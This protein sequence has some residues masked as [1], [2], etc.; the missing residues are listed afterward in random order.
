MGSLRT[1]FQ[2]LLLISITFATKIDIRDRSLTCG[3]DKSHTLCLPDVGDACKIN[4]DYLVGIGLTVKEQEEM[5]DL[6]N[7]YRAEVA[8]GKVS[9]LPP[10]ANMHQLKWNEDLAQVAQKWADQCLFDHDSGS[11]RKIPAFDK[12]GQNIYLQKISKRVPG[13]KVKKA[14]KKWFGE[15]QDF[16]EN[17]ISPFKFTYDTGHFSQV[18]WAETSEVMKLFVEEKV[19]FC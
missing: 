18:V 19:K 13:L 7:K 17:Q 5:V 6:H 2:L 8:E 16:D 3:E 10:A 4:D 12:V 9:G 11:A 15:V 14:V 1:I